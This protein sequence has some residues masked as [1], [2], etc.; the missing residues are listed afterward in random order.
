M[1]MNY[2]ML[3]KHSLS[4][5]SKLPFKVNPT[6]ESQHS[7]LTLRNTKHTLIDIELNFT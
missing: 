5:Y 4:Y 1:S 7:Q 2:W 3:M 6:Q